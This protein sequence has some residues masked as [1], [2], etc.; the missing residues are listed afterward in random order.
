[1]YE[2]YATHWNN[3]K[4]VVHWMMN[5]PWPS[6]FGHLFDAYFKPGGGY[7]GA[8][9]ALRP[10]SIVWDYYA[11]GDRSTARVYVVN[12]SAQPR[13]FTASV[14][15][16]T[17]DG[18]RKSYREVK[19]FNVPAN[20]SAEAMRVQRAEGLGPVYLVRCQL[21]DAAGALV[22]ENVY[23]QS[24]HDDDLGDPKNDEQF[25]TNLAAWGD[26]SA[27]N[28]MPN[29]HLDAS[30]EFTVENGDAA[31]KVKLTNPSNQVAFFVRA[32]ITKGADGEEIV[33]ITYDDNYVTIFP[34]ET[35][36]IVARFAMPAPG[37][38][39]PA[40]R[41]EGYNTPKNVLTLTRR[42]TPR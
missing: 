23:W 20:S 33:P 40:L 35:R 12:R 3:R 15:F 7:F 18:M 5:N 21:K 10:I 26:M 24:A 37:N 22:S 39:S 30:S 4:M 41:V 14:A 17:L 36:T 11:T 32:E 9:K 29:A 25:K 1:Q 19:N 16:Y 34:H 2:S 38:W 31:A 42:E 13:Q 8:K 6:F 27:L 28:S